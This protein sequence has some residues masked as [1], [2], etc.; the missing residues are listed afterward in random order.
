MKTRSLFIALSFIVISFA[1]ISQEISDKQIAFANGFIKAVGD[2]SEK[3]TM[4]YL[5]KTYR[6]EQL[7]FLKGNHKQLVN[8]L[9]G[10]QDESDRDIYLNFKISEITKI[11]IVEVIQLKGTSECTYIFKLKRG[12]QEIFSSLRLKVKG[13]K[14][15]FE[16]GRG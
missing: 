11:E 16:G 4:K 13:K 8:E 7:E 12:D 15:G 14:F 3:K 1:G 2:H 9:F 5:D 10:G 6:K